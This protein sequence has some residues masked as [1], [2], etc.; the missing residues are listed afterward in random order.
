MGRKVRDALTQFSICAPADHVHALVRSSESDKPLPLS[1]SIS[2]APL[3]HLFFAV[4]SSLKSLNGTD[5]YLIIPD[6]YK[7]LHNVSVQPLISAQGVLILTPAKS[8]NQL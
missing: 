7:Y 5:E 8:K 4:N 3:L 2:F 6:S 1:S